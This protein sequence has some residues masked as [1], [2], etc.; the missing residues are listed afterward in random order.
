MCRTAGFRVHA[1]NTLTRNTV[2]SGPTAGFLTDGEQCGTGAHPWTDNIAHSVRD[3]L[4]VADAPAEEFY[5]W[6]AAGSPSSCRK[7]GGVLAHAIGDHGLMAWYT[8]GDLHVADFQAVDATVGAGALVM[9]SGMATYHDTQAV[10]YSDSAFAGHWDNAP[11]RATAPYHFKCK[12]S[13]T[14]FAPWCK[15]EM[16]AQSAPNVGT[17]GIMET[18]FADDQMGGKTVGEHKF[19]WLEMDSVAAVDARAEHKNVHFQNFDGTDAC[20]NKNVA[21]HQSPYS[22]DTFHQHTF[23]KITWSNIKNGGEFWARRTYGNTGK[24][25]DAATQTWYLDFDN[26]KYG[27]YWPDAPNAAIII[28]KDGSFAG[29]SGRSSIVASES[30]TRPTQFKDLRYDGRGFAD[31][32]LPGARTGCTWKAGWSAYACDSTFNWVTIAIENLA[33]D[34]T[35]RRPGPVVLCKGDGMII[36][37]GDPICQ[38]G[39]INYASGPVMKGKAGRATLERLSQ[40]WLAAENLGNYTLSYRGQPP[41]WQRFHLQGHEYLNA[42]AGVVLNLR[43][44][45]LNSASRVGVYV[46]GKRQRPVV[47]YGYPYT[48]GMTWP[49]PL[50]TPGTH[51]HD[52]FVDSSIIRATGQGVQRNIM[53]FVVRP[54]SAIDLRQEP[55]IQINV[56]LAIPETAF[57]GQKDIFVAAMASVLGIDASRLKF[58]KIVPGGAASA[59]RRATGTTDLGLELGQSEAEATANYNNQTRAGTDV[60]G[61]AGLLTKLNA[62]AAD[63]SALATAGFTVNSMSSNILQVQI[64]QQPISVTYGTSYIV[65]NVTRGADVVTRAH[66]TGS[67]VNYVVNTTAFA[68]GIV[69]ASILNASV[70][71]DIPTSSLYFEPATGKTRAVVTMLYD[72][73]PVAS[74]EALRKLS[75]VLAAALPGYA[76]T[77]AEFV[78]NGYGITPAPATTAAPAS[79]SE[80]TTSTSLD[81]LIADHAMWF[82]LGAVVG[83]LAL[84]A[85]ALAVGYYFLR[86]VPQR[87]AAAEQAALAKQNDPY[88]LGSDDEA[89]TANGDDDA[90]PVIV[91]GTAD[92]PPA[93][94]VAKSLFVGDEDQKAR[95]ARGKSA[96]ALPPT[97]RSTLAPQHDASEA[98][99]DVAPT[100]PVRRHQRPAP[101]ATDD[102]QERSAFTA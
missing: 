42:D 19:R 24:M 10:S 38:G 35:T 12:K 97:R 53:S 43:Y 85:V 82:I 20:G 80:T 81:A 5:M 44:F 71:T 89:D 84:I 29:T 54:G 90:A 49:A 91:T 59:A 69:N 78:N 87:R 102:N 3:G 83:V 31:G 55:I 36:A 79:G 1:G 60:N 94:V 61:F 8:T 2:A 34:R 68:D 39:V 30:I 26:Y 66:M 98:F 51:Y 46:N 93:P 57:F 41:V 64:A 23:E 28:D 77:D 9:S 88:L 17:I 96:A 25:T 6:D 76:V 67:L 45:G 15:M 37:N 72:D 7:V 48:V 56:N 50:D 73:Q 63:P 40:Y 58:A 100:N 74:H 47:Q 11:C 21:F 14:D 4:L 92:E 27:A 75:T 16:F 13:M 101:P 70:A 52:K 95:Q 32:K 65:M 22:N 99:D 62:L 18:L 33:E 86:V